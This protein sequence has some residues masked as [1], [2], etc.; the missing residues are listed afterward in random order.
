[1][2]QDHRTGSS[3]FVT[4]QFQPT[5]KP[6]KRLLWRPCFW[7]RFGH[8]LKHDH[9]SVPNSLFHNSCVRGLP[10]LVV[11]GHNRLGYAA[12]PRC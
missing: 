2:A 8:G 5:Q 7:L 4:P 11:V 3:G 6:H 10:R 12:K 9:Q 1:M